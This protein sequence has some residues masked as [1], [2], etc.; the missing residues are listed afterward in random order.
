MGLPVDV[1]L[2]V[3]PT[4]GGKVLMSM[5]EGGMQYMIS[6][7]R[8][9]VGIKAGRYMYEVKII[10]ALNPAESSGAQRGRV[11]MP[12]QLVRLGFSTSSAGLILGDTE[13][14]VCFD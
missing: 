12:R 13:E 11:P 6:G 9:N 1:T 8:A 10:E 14:G 3:V 4:M 2:N 7:A 5:S